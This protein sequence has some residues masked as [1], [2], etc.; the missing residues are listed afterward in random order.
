MIRFRILIACILACVILF[1]IYI[2]FAHKKS[3][4]ILE[5][6]DLNLNEN[7]INQIT[8]I[9]QMTEIYPMYLVTESQEQVNLILTELKKLE[10]TPVQIDEVKKGWEFMFR[11]HMDDDKKI[12]LSFSKTMATSSNYS[13]DVIGY[14][15][16][17][18]LE[19]FNTIDA[20]KLRYP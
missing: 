10:F 15:A 19:L 4:S 12:N 13:Y 1:V 6:P 17:E 2:A 14:D 20:E 16:S 5:L 18:F 7:Q 8:I 9:S 11:F 3:L